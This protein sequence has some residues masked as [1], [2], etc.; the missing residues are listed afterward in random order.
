KNYQVI[1]L[2]S[3]IKL[4]FWVDA[5]QKNEGRILSS[6]SSKFPIPPDFPSWE[7]WGWVDSFSLLK[8]F[9]SKP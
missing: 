3:C 8:D 9:F 1:V 2:G 5:R 4:G 6:A 7:G